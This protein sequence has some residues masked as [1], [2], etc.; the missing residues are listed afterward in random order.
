MLPAANSG[1]LIDTICKITMLC[2]PLTGQL[3]SLKTEPLYNSQPWAA[4]Y[5]LRSTPLN[6]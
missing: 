2:Y 4:P 1:T 5:P 6:G 3:P